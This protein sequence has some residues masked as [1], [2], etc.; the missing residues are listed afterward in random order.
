MRRANSGIVNRQAC[1]QGFHWECDHLNGFADAGRSQQDNVFGAGGKARVASSNLPF[2]DG[3]LKAEVNSSRLFSI[4][5]TGQLC[6]HFFAL[7]AAFLLLGGQKLVKVGISV[8][9]VQ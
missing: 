4:W 1:F 8:F 5:K 2:V 6:P 3:R 9:R 7:P